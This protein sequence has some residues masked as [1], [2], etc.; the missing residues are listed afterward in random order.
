[1]LNRDMHKF[2]F[3]LRPN[4]IDSVEF[5]TFPEF[6]NFTFLVKMVSRRSRKCLMLRI[7][8]K[9]FS[10]AFLRNKFLKSM[11]DASDEENNKTI[12]ILTM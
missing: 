1:M 10:L 12:I 4:S 7:K 11:R 3:H 9:T 8:G 5:S 6:F 2:S